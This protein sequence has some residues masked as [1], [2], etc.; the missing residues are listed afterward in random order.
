MVVLA[1]LAN[2]AYFETV[3]RFLFEGKMFYFQLF[4]H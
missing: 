3:K 2:I 1:S 4:M